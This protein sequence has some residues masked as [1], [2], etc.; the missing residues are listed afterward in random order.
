MLFFRNIIYEAGFI[1]YYP[2]II[3]TPN[4]QQGPQT[5]GFI[6]Q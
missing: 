4:L 5:F 1:Y 6:T 3:I 2:L